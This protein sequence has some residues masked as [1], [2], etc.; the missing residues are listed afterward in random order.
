MKISIKIRLFLPLVVI[1]A[2]ISCNR[3]EEFPLEPAI[4][5]IEFEKLLNVTD[6]IYDRGVLKFKFTDGDGDIG[7]RKSDTFPPFHPGSKY[8]YNLVIDYYEVRNGVE[9]YVPL[10]FYNANTQQFDTVYLS[11]RIPMLTPE[12]SNKPISGE[13]HDTIFIYNYNSPFDTLFLK[14]YIVDRALNE[15]NVERTDYIVRRDAL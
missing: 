10:V 7:L 12:G 8:Y 9:T 11:A 3:T 5:F 4:S 2:T 1:L 13:I 6:N 15:S 14:F